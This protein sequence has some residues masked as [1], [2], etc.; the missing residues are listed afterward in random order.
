LYH[1]VEG[2]AS[3]WAKAPYRIETEVAVDFRI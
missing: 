3:I 1:T 2:V